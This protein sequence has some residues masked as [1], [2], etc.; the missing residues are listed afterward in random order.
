[1]S[2]RTGRAGRKGTAVLIVPIPR[3]RRVEMM[4]RGARIAAEWVPVPGAAD[5]HERDRARLL[6]RL[7]APLEDASEQDRALAAQLLERR[8]PAEL[9]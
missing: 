2:G 5:V 4:L 9:A 1:R 3:R 6:E 8:D 7:S